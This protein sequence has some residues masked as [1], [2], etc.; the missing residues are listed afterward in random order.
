MKTP[1]GL[2]DTSAPES[3]RPGAALVAGVVAGLTSGAV[4]M[5]WESL[6]PPRTPDREVPPVTLL[7]QRGI[8]PDEHTYEYN[9]NQVPWGVLAVHFGFSVVTVAAYSVAA[10]YFPRTK[11]WAGAAYG[12]GAFVVAHEIVLPRLGLSPAAKDLPPEEHFSELFGHLA[13]ML[14]AE[15][16]R[17]AVRLAVAGVPDADT[18]TN[19]IAKLADTARAAVRR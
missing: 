7:Q 18:R 5:G 6:F 4:K 3:R 1:F 11:L 19:A 13:W 2:L 17:K 14:E 15:Q 12:L 16:I 9:G 10:E 8:D